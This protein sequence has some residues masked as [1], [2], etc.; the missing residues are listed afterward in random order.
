V[1]N[2]QY[3]KPDLITSV[4]RPEPGFGSVGPGGPQRGAQAAATSAGRRNFGAQA[5]FEGA[6]VI[7]LGRDPTRPWARL[8]DDRRRGPESGPRRSLSSGLGVGPAAEGSQVR[9]GKAR[10]SGSAQRRR[11]AW[12]LSNG[13]L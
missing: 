13:W 7:V 8:Q 6:Q 11:A 10:R 9:T 1:G 2:I 5:G 4:W 3:A 12:L